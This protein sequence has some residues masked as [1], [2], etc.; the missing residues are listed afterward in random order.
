MII[1]ALSPRT[2]VVVSIGLL[3]AALLV[4]DALAHPVID[5]DPA[6]STATATSQRDPG[7]AAALTSKH[8]LPVDQAPQSL[9]VSMPDDRR[10]ASPAD[11]LPEIDSESSLRL[12][13][14][15]QPPIDARP[16]LPG[17]KEVAPLPTGR[18]PAGQ[19]GT[20][21]DLASSPPRPAGSAHEAIPLAGEEI[22]AVMRD[23]EESV[24]EAI[25]AATDAQIGPE[26][27]ASFSLFGME[28]FHF[29]AKGGQVSIGHGDLSLSVIEHAG[30]R[31]G[32]QTRQTAQRGP[33]QLSTPGEPDGGWTIR[34][35]ILEIVQYPL[36]WVVIL[37]LLIGK[38]ALTIASR[39]GRRRTHR[40][41][42]RSSQQ[43]KVKRMRTRKRVRIRLKRP[44]SPASL[45][46]P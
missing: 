36:F 16:A 31:D 20:P 14:Q 42:S 40:R 19:R 21:Q 4:A 43:V 27:R 46:E 30:S 39:R 6:L 44:R 32:E 3:P 2:R 10:F 13:E 45:Q 22:A 15:E 35:F 26:G 33:Q 11:T 7:E 38:M 41:H 5:H 1:G 37:M 34:Q 9:P 24:V 28:G 8:S 23:L 29:A 18:R 25:V 12:F 17:D